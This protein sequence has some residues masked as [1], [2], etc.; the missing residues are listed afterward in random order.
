M[1]CVLNLFRAS[2]EAKLRIKFF[3]KFSFK[4]A[5]GAAEVY[6]HLKEDLQICY[7]IG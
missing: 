5:R 2:V 3:A 1:Q 6:F 4:K 7:T